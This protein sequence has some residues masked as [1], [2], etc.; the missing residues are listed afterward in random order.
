LSVPEEEQFISSKRRLFLV[1]LTL[2]LRVFGAQWFFCCIVSV[3]CL[4]C[5]PTSSWYTL[6]FTVCLNCHF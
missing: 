3:P 1:C 2:S 5:F 6:L 4:H